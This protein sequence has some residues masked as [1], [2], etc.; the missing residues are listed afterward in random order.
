MGVTQGEVAVL[1]EIDPTAFSH[2]L[3]GRRRPPKDFELRVEGALSAIEAA[4]AAYDQ[5]LADRGFP[6]AA[7]SIVQH[8]VHR[9]PHRHER[10]KGTGESPMRIRALVS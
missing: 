8:A 10:R 9:R 4:R 2:I 1:C 6:E 3:A 5:V 7:S